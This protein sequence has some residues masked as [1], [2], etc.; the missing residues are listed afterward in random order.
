MRTHQRL[1][2]PQSSS[3]VLQIAAD[4][5]LQSSPT[6]SLVTGGW[7]RRHFEA[8][9]SSTE[10]FRPIIRPVPPPRS[11]D[12]PPKPAKKAIPSRNKGNSEE[13]TAAE[14]RHVLPSMESPQTK[15]PSSNWKTRR[16]VLDESGQSRRMCRSGEL[17]L[18]ARM[19]RK[20]RVQALMNGSR[21]R[22]EYSKDF[23]KEGGLIPGSTIRIG[24]N[25]VP[26]EVD[27]LE[28]AKASVAAKLRRDRDRARE[29]DIRLD[30]TQV[31]ELSVIP[32]P[33]FSL[34]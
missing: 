23:F 34:T 3:G 20:Q 8:P 19:S 11:E 18:S 24:K 15:F 28:S 16:V 5:T 1:H 13:F 12:R 22:A 7:A 21:L 14:K 30:R 25:S 9:R 10:T 26:R 32:P 27:I 4:P 6:S 17:D 33:R 29:R 2:F 31:E